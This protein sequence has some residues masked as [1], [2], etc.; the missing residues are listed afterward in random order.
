M[1]VV[2][3]RIGFFCHYNT[4]DLHIRIV[5]NTMGKWCGKRT[6]LLHTVCSKHGRF[7]KSLPIMHPFESIGGYKHSIDLNYLTNK[8]SYLYDVLHRRDSIKTGIGGCSYDDVII[9]FWGGGGF[10]AK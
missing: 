2:Q 6:T 1:Y 5:H 8:V 7:C 3:E 10:F 9:F 4:L